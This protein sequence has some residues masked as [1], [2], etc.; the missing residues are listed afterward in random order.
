MP[1]IHIGKYMHVYFCKKKHL[2]TTTDIAL[3]IKII[4]QEYENIQHNGDKPFNMLIE[5][6]DNEEEIENEQ[7]RYRELEAKLKDK[8]SRKEYYLTQHDVWTIHFIDYID[9]EE[10]T[11]EVLI[12]LVEEIKVFEE[13]QIEITFK[14]KSP[15]VQEN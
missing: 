14:F 1:Q 2:T 6:S 8:Q 13:K 7:R 5:G 11:R 9:I 10:I 3:A 15:F 4:D 12:A